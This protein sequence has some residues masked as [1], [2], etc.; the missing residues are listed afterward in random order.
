MSP[1]RYR[2]AHPLEP[3]V[4]PSLSA[5]VERHAVRV[6]RILNPVGLFQGSAQSLFRED[7]AN[8]V[9]CRK[10]DDL[11]LVDRLR[12]HADDVGPLLLDHLAVVGVKVGYPVPLG[13][14]LQAALAPSRD[15]HDLGLI[16]GVV[17]R[18]VAVWLTK[19]A[20]R[21]LPFEQAANA[22]RPDDCHTIFCVPHSDASTPRVR[23]C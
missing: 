21:T 4:V 5:E 19:R 10:D 1:L 9:L 7:A 13:E 18:E 8:P 12:R 17:G 15:R 3:I 6:D 2:L 20:R 14:H 16:D 11:C 22:S 23:F